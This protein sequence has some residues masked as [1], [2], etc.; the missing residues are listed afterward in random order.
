MGVVVYLEKQAILT[1][2]VY[3]SYLSRLFQW[4]WVIEVIL[5]IK[6]SEDCVSGMVV[7]H[8]RGPR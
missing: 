3:S 7:E 8:N 1:A 5:K 4:I 6:N 2:G